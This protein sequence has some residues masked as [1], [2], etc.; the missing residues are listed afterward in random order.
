MEFSNYNIFWIDQTI[1]TQLT[2]FDAGSSSSW[3]IFQFWLMESKILVL[4]LRNTFSGFF[5][6]NEFRSN[7]PILIS[8]LVIVVVFRAQKRISFWNRSIK[9]F[10]SYSK[11]NHD[12]KKIFSYFFLKFFEISQ[13]LSVQIHRKFNFE[14]NSLERRLGHSNQFS[15]SKLLSESQSHTHTLTQLKSSGNIMQMIKCILFY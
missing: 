6:S 10:E 5:R 12:Q 2:A 11:K 15:R 13:N 3:A 8:L 9:P 4:S 14:E 7:Q 1:S